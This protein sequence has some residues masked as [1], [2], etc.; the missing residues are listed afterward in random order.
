MENIEHL[1][2][3]AVIRLGGD[4]RRDFLQ[5]LITQDIAR[6]TPEDAL[7]TTLLTPQG[8]VLF[9]FFVV[10]TGDA[11]LIDC[12]RETAPTLAKRL[13]LYKLRAKVTIEIDDALKV[14]A[15]SKDISGHDGD[16]F[17]D[18]RLPALGWRAIT[19]DA[20]S[21]GGDDYDNRRIALGVPEFGKDFSSDDMF[22]LD[23]N[24]DALNGVSY[25]K[26]CFVGQEVTSRMKRKGEARRRTLI[27][28]FD[29][30]APARGASITAGASTLGEI[31]SSVNGQALALIRLDR[32]RKSQ[33]AGDAQECEG[34]PLRL[35]IPAYLE[36]V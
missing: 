36:P 33:E 23:V 32:W 22:L 8:K 13:T 25:K 29:G 9:D 30:A 24:Y 26:G 2:N 21:T 12:D 34:K 31:L 17:A 11:Y 35:S 15:S 4:E 19:S 7:F 3:R 10:E 16:A 27:A 28:E 14:I 6:L 5:G 1:A 20:A 18:P